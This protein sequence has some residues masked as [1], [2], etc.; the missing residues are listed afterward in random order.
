MTTSQIKRRRTVQQTLLRRA[1]QT[2]GFDKSQDAVEYS[3]RN[4][5]GETDSKVVLSSGPTQERPSSRT[6]GTLRRVPAAGTPAQPASGERKTAGKITGCENL[7]KALSSSRKP[8]PNDYNRNVSG[9]RSGSTSR[10]STRSRNSSCAYPS[11]W[12]VNVSREE[13]MDPNSKGSLDEITNCS[14][15]NQTPYDH[16]LN[17]PLKLVNSCQCP[18]KNKTRQRIYKSANV[19]GAQT[20]APTQSSSRNHSSG[21]R[22]NPRI[23]SS[24]SSGVR[25]KCRVYSG[26]EDRQNVCPSKSNSEISNSSKCKLNCPGV[27]FKNYGGYSPSETECDTTVENNQCQCSNSYLT[28]IDKVSKPPNMYENPEVWSLEMSSATQIQEQKWVDEDGHS[29]IVT[30]SDYNSTDERKSS[31]DRCTCKCCSKK[32][33]RDRDSHCKCSSKTTR[34]KCP[35]KDEKVYRCSRRTRDA[36]TSWSRNSSPLASSDCSEN[37]YKSSCKMHHVKITNL[38]CERKSPKEKSC[39]KRKTCSDYGYIPT[40]CKTDTTKNKRQDTE[41][42]IVQVGPVEIPP[43]VPT[44]QGLQVILILWNLVGAVI[45]PETVKEKHVKWSTSVSPVKLFQV[46]NALKRLPRRQK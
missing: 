29:V 40:E 25:L 26:E 41:H 21:G 4:Q 6:V 43:T 39:P 22:T 23:G 27:T 46:E 35:S 31:T 17:T 9:Q 8:K 20:P 42:G 44:G 36:S 30:L 12:L 11:K 7:R 24:Q 19:S 38:C 16:N 1:C 2:Q 3:D 32:P 10:G 45:E 37:D 13:A 28:K 33:R 18:M 34:R 14:L 15:L 5:N